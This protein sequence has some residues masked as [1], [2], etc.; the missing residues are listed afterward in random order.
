MVNQ[1]L[2]FCLLLEK[3]KMFK[4]CLQ[5]SPITMSALYGQDDDVIVISKED[6]L[7]DNEAEGDL[8]TRC[9]EVDMESPREAIL[10]EDLSIT[11]QKEETNA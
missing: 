10:N 3:L 11:Q 4:Y 5:T 6:N 9:D 2:K 7:V 1:L 8:K